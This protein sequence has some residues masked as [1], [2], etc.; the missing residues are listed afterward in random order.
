MD[1]WIHLP[2]N[3]PDGRILSTRRTEQG[4]WLIRVESTLEGAQC[5]RCG[6]AMRDLHGWDAV[7]RLRPLPLFDVPV[8]VELRPK[9]SRCPCCSGNPTT[10]QRCEWYEP[11]CPHTQAYEPWAVRMVIN[12]TVTDA[13]HTLGVSEEAIAGLLDRWSERAVEW[14]A[15]ER[16]GVIGLDEI[17]LTRGHR[18]VVVWVTVPLAEGGV[19]MVAGRADRQQ[20]AVAAFLR[21]RPETLRR[22]R[23]YGYVRRLR[24]RA[25]RGGAG[26]RTRQRSVPR[27]TGLARL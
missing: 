16:L 25:R 12:A 8:F 13:A 18:D 10:T 11:R 27:G 4:H 26:G 5:R 22:A 20:E 14:D 19:A 3:V 17:A 6:R 15:W 1:N 23:A 9:R 24:E 21:A 7:V 2:L